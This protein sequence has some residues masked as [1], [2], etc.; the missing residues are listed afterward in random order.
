MTTKSLPT[1]AQRNL[2]G[3]DRYLIHIKRGQQSGLKY[4]NCHVSPYRLYISVQ[5]WLKQTSWLHYRRSIGEPPFKIAS[6]PHKWP[7]HPFTSPFWVRI[8]YFV[9]SFTQLMLRYSRLL[10]S[11]LCLSFIAQIVIYYRSLVCL[12]AESLS[13]NLKY[14]STTGNPVNFSNN[15]NNRYSVAEE[16]NGDAWWRQET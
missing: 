3:V 7:S 5:R 4:E 9:Y 15:K 6:Q 2:S 1:S 16:G 11:T 10:P 12:T 8:L 13:I 14:R